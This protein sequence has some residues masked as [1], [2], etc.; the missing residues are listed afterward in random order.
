MRTNSPITWLFQRL[1]LFSA[2]F[3]ACFAENATAQSNPFAN[4]SARAQ[5]L[6]GDKVVISGFVINTTATTTKQVVIRG[7]GPSLS[8]SGSGADSRPTPD[9]P[10][11]VGYMSD[12]TLTLSGPNGL[13]LSNNN[14]RDTQESAILATGLQPTN[15]LESAMVVTLG[16]GAYTVTLAGN[17]GGTGLGI[18]EMYDIAGPATIFNLSTRAQV[19]TGSTVL[20]GGVIVRAPGTRAV[21]RAIGPS[22]SQHGIQGALQ[23]PMLELYNAQGTLI[24]ANDN[25]GSD[26]NQAE[27]Q[28]VGLQPS[29][30][31]ESAIL[32]TLNAGNYTVIVKGVMNSTGIG[33][34]ELYAL[35]DPKYPR[36]FQAWSNADN[37]P[38]DPLVTV[39]RH[40]LFWT[41]DQGFGWNWVDGS[42]QVTPD[43]TSETISFTNPNPIYPIPT[44]RSLNPDIKI[45]VQ[46]TL[47]DLKGDRLP[48]NH[49]WWKRDGSGNRVPVSEGSEYY[50]LN[51]DNASLRTHIANQA[52]A[53][54]QTG[55]F[56]GVLF[57]SISKVTPSLRLPILTEVR[58]TIGENGLIIVN[59]NWFQ[60]TSAELSKI[61]GVFMECGKIGAGFGGYPDWQT[62]K[63]ALIHNETYTRVPKVNCLENWYITS[64]TAASDLKRLRA[65]T[66]L[67]LTVSNGYALFSDPND[68]PAVDHLHNWYDPFWSNHSLGVPTGNNY[69]I[70]GIASRR[71]F[72]NGSAIWNASTTTSVSVTFSETRKS[73]ATGTIKTAGQSFSVPASDGDIFIK[74]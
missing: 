72:K 59:N 52:A 56:D 14:W 1:A 44:L 35:A 25:W 13:I 31:F 20:I 2:V 64:R 17:N 30:A 26:P 74:I 33:L 54:M 24:E 43:Y 66:T 23:N 6:T 55:Q 9:A 4:V 7:L 21:V 62:V 51:L 15:N 46:V 40:D 37:L 34:V 63:A 69:T 12:P 48:S 60:L 11:A 32:P 58:N 50:F 38:E 18:V 5:V 47:V 65:T 61:N 10:A 49:Q 70:S 42:G 41:I 45:L 29:N 71:D 67:S 22:L 53:L 36:I 27:I 19:G 8:V 28:Y 39:A 3:A 16:P 73:L 57:D 68:L